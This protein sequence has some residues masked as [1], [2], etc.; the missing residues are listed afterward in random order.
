MKPTKRSLPTTD[1]YLDRSHPNVKGQ[2]S[3]KIRVTYRR[4]TKY[5]KTGIFLSTQEYGACCEIRNP[6]GQNKIQRI[7]FEDLLRKSK[8]IIKELTIFTFDGWEKC[9]YRSNYDNDSL[10]YHFNKKISILLSR[11]KYSSAESYENPMR[12][13]LRNSKPSYKRRR[14][15]THH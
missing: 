7:E 14:K 12:I 3:V 9:F 10:V 8:S 5:F 2:C 11:E 15:P 13:L 6:R 4:K 1:I